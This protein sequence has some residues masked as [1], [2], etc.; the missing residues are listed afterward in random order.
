MDSYCDL[1]KLI[2]SRNRN[3]VYNSWSSA[4][5][6]LSSLFR[7]YITF[8][9]QTFWTNDLFLGW[10][11]SFVIFLPR[12]STLPFYTISFLTELTRL[13]SHDL[14]IHFLHMPSKPRSNFGYNFQLPS[15]ANVFLILNWSFT[16]M[17]FQSFMKAWTKA[18]YVVVVFLYAFFL[19][20]LKGV[21]FSF[22]FFS[23]FVVHDWMLTSEKIWFFLFFCWF[24]LML[25]NLRW[26]WM[27]GY[28]VFL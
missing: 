6:D 9:L 2:N 25:W 8:W 13:I 27:V 12:K 7:A 24:I 3:Y 26:I 23:H 5:S 4:A 19:G 20:A 17:D 1:Y 10:V 18:S 15:F 22:T 21:L 28:W 11:F 14:P 16:N